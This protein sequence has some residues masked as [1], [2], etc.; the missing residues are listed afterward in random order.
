MAA[1]KLTKAQKLELLLA[2]KK[3]INTRADRRPRW[4]NAEYGLCTN[5]EILC[6]HNP[7]AKDL[8]DHHDPFKKLFFE[9]VKTWPHYSGDRDF[10]VPAVP[11][12]R[13]PGEC[14]KSMYRASPNMYDR[15]VSYCK[16]RHDLLDH[17]IKCV[18]NEQ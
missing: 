4:F 11:S 1:T 10:Y 7:N 15:R 2:L 13:W 5:F 6:C 16:L 17:V 14:A 9:H 12:D 8:V 18:E 3:V